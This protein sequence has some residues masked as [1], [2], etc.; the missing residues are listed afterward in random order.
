MVV[1]VTALA[2]L[3]VVFEEASV[4][5][6]LALAVECADAVGGFAGGHHIAYAVISS[7]NFNRKTELPSYEITILPEKSARAS[8]VSKRWILSSILTAC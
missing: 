3:D 8:C 4:A 7:S 5:L 1:V 6:L 2:L